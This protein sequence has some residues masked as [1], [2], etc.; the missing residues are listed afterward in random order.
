MAKIESILKTEEIPTAK[1]TIGKI[2]KYPTAKIDFTSTEVL[3]IKYL[4][5]IY[6]LLEKRGYDND[7]RELTSKNR[8]SQFCGYDREGKAIIKE[9]LNYS[10]V[11]DN[12]DEEVKNEIKKLLENIPYVQRVIL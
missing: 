8:I 1:I 5:K 7:K 2:V 9:R 12:L 10:I 11:Y 4:W 3:D 6:S